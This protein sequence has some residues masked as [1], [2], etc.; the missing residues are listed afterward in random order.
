MA[1]SAEPL[2]VP[3]EVISPAT[4]VLVIISFI[5]ISIMGGLIG[6]YLYTQKN[7]E[8]LNKGI[9]SFLSLALFALQ[10]LHN[11]VGIASLSSRIAVTIRNCC[12]SCFRMESCWLV[13]NFV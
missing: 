2:P 9:C 13:Q 5:V 6:L 1:D 12:A 7:P 8:L 10:G 11:L 4:S 3:D